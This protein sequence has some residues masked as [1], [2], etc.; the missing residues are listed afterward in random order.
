MEQLLFLGN[1]SAIDSYS[2]TIIKTA[3]ATFTALMGQTKFA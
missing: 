2:I 1:A 3:N